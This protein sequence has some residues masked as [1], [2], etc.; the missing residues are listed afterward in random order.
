MLAFTVCGTLGLGAH[1]VWPAKQLPDHGPSQ[2]L[3][4]L[5]AAYLPALVIVLR[6]QR[7]ATAALE[8]L[9]PVRAGGLL[10]A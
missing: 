1:Y 4:V 5:L 3:I 7:N 10:P 2:W 9:Q 8:P 6:R